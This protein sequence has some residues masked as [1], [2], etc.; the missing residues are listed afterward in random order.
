[1]INKMFLLSKEFLITAF[2]VGA[3]RGVFDDLKLLSKNTDL[4]GFEPDKDECQKLNS[5]LQESKNNYKSISYYPYALGETKDKIDLNLYSQ[6]GCSSKY[7]VK[8]KVAES[9]SRSDY[10]D[11]KGVFNMDVVALDSIVE[12]NEVPSPDFIKID[13]Q[14]M[15][16]EVFRGG[17]KCIKS[18]V[19]GIRTEAYFRE[20]YENQPLFNDIDSV[21]R[22]FG[23]VPIRFLEMHE[24]RRLTKVK[25]PKLASIDIPYSY[26]E[27]MH[28]DI[29]Y[30]L[31]PEN[32]NITG[33]Q[34]IKK[35]IKAALVALCYKNYDYAYTIFSNSYIS[36]YVS[37]KFR[38]NVFE[39]IS[40]LSIKHKNEFWLTR[41]TN[42]LN[43]KFNL[44]GKK[45]KI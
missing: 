23:F 13:V 4:I 20:L 39:L 34:D 8:R 10:F 28:V 35:Y 5:E 45:L 25:H 22:S 11:E 16:V 9:F 2:D 41:I 38:I 36:A 21:L 42:Y 26:G 12:S 33:E 31:D 27:M 43:E 40:E 14:G 6:P 24:W 15:E 29:L 3:R 17:E 44:N 7:K 1:M 30:L 37:D 19:V 18:S 32:I